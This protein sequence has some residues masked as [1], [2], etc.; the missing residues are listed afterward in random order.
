MR[1]DV[2]TLFPKMF[3]F[4]FSEGV[5]SRA[6]KNKIIEL[7]LINIRNFSNHKNK[8]VDDYP[9]GGGCGMIMQAQPIFDAHLNIFKKLNYK[10]TTIYLTPQGKTLKQKTVEMMS[11][12]KHL[13][14]LCGHYEGVDQRVLDEIVDE[15]ISIGDFILTGGEIAAMIIIDSV[16]RLIPKVLKNEN[17][18]ICETFQN[19]LLE[20]PQYTRPN[21]WNGKQV[22]SVLLNG[23]HKKIKYWRKKQ[24]ILLTLAKR[25]DLID[26]NKLN[27]DE[28]E[29]IKN[30]K[31]LKK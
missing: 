5:I 12:Q 24:S 28:K 14:L 17:S 10:P 30:F 15:E 3:E 31:K 26:L 27:E 23:N 16:S 13:I 18:K 11:K 7:N 2:L 25:Q 8:N 20:Y 6:I 9:Y 19:N 29:F 22:P 4:A 1:F 21:I